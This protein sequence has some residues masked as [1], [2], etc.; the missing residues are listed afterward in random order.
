MLLKLLST[1]TFEKLNRKYLDQVRKLHQEIDSGLSLLNLGNEDDA[2]LTKS[3][4]LAE[5][6]N[7]IANLDGTP[8]VL[9]DTVASGSLFAPAW[10]R[11]M[12]SSSEAMSVC[13]QVS[14]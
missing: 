10:R 2:E 14:Q 9:R 5:A 4:S 6:V 3:L 8:Q 13:G 1:K 11:A 7:T 12:S